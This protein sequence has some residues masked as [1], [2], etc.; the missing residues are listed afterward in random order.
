MHRRCDSWSC[1]DEM[2]ARLGGIHTPVRRTTR[3]CIVLVRIAS[4]GAALPV[5]AQQLPQL[6]PREIFKRR[7][8]AC[9]GDVTPGRALMR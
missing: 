2:R 8:S 1:S 7:S 4:C 9:T 3:L 6:P 5:N